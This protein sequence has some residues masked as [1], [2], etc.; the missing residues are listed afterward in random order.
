MARYLC[1]TTDREKKYEADSVKQIDM[2][3][4]GADF[5]LRVD[6]LPMKA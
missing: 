2:A 1:V 3:Y 5:S 6:S 4:L